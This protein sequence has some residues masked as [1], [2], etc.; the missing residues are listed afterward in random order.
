MSV[1]RLLLVSVLWLAACEPP[2]APSAPSGPLPP[3]VVPPPPQTLAE[4]SAEK[5]YAVDLLA[6]A[7]EFEKNRPDATDGEFHV[8]RSPHATV[9]LHLIGVGQMCPL[10][11]HRTTHEATV[12]VRGMPE[13]VHVH[14]ATGSLKEETRR[15]PAGTLV[16]SPPFTG[17]QWTNVEPV[18]QGNLVIASP[19]FDG[20]LYLH[21]NDPRMLPG[22]A[23]TL[24]DPAVALAEA[25]TSEL[26][27][28]GLLD[29]QLS[30]ALVRDSLPLHTDAS[31][32]T[33]LYVALGEGDLDGQPVRPG[34]AVVL[35]GGEPVAL[36]AT[37]PE[38]LAAWVFTPPRPQG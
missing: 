1:A 36:K 13:V 22:P 6:R 34:V 31:R 21:P 10:H 16:Y 35:S 11:I 2:K 38:G 24:L 8:Y 17:H 29:G 3:A 7:A 27:P 37:S 25:T 12:I 4:A 5:T 9:H 32:D 18:P 20:N 30:L 33:V 19:K 26:Q 15:V 28:T 14:G 23:P